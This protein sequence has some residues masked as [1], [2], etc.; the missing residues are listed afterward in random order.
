MA[1]QAVHTPSTVVGALADS[2]VVVVAEATSMVV[3]VTTKHRL[4]LTTTT[5]DSTRIT[6]LDSLLLHTRFPSPNPMAT[7]S[8]LL[9]GPPSTA[10][11]SIISSLM[12]RSHCPPPT[13][14]RTTLLSPTHKRRSILSNNS[15]LHTA[16]PNSM[17][18]AILG[19]RHQTC[20]IGQDR[21]HSNHLRMLVVAD[22]VVPKHTMA[23]LD[24]GDQAMNMSKCLP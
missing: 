15:S 5:R 6:V 17:A 14:T 8:S 7:L 9:T 18:R 19:P 12:L 21:L 11:P 2:K 13:I 10:M 22:G 4:Q 24:Q 16:P 23:V 1:T 20:H 3:E